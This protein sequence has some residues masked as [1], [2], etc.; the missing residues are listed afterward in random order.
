MTENENNKVGTYP[1]VVEPFHADFTGKLTMG[2]WA[3][4]C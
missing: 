2:Y 4:I 3:T 1:F